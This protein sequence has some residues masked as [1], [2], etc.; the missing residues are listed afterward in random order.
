MGKK[1]LIDTNII[2]YFSMNALPEKIDNNWFCQLFL[3]S[4]QISIITK[5]EFLGWQK[6]TQETYQKAKDLLEEATIFSLN[7]SIVDQT[8]NLRRQKNI[9][10]PDA[11]IAATSQ[12]YDLTLV[13][14][15]EKDF[16]GINNITIYNP[17]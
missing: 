5:I 14:R 3:D 2:I 8:I 9:K 10:L 11:I 16:I 15:N 1:F 13:T 4:F 17:F 7:S 6:H 12:L